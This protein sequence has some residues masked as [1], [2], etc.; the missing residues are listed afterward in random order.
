M[1]TITKEF[2]EKVRLALLAIRPNFDG[3]DGAFAKQWSI[4]GAVFSR[5]QKGQVDGVL[6]DV[7]WITIGRELGV[8]THEKKWNTAK[9]DVFV[10]IEQ[11]VLFCKEH[12][13]AKIFVDAC[14]I[15]KT[16]TAKYLSKTLRNCFYIDGSQ[17]KTKQQ[18]VRRIAKALGVDQIGTYYDVKENIKY[19]LKLLPYPIIIIDEAGDITNDAF[20]ELKE[21]WNAT[22]GYCGW[23]MIGA[24][25]LRA[26]IQRGITN[27]KVGY[28][29]IFSRF[30]S[31]YSSVVPTDRNEKVSFYKKLLVDVLEVNAVDK[32]TINHIVNKCIT[33]DDKDNIGGL[34]RAEGILIL[35]S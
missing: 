3:S 28:R 30:S 7:H 31:K 9:T 2:K 29:E 23:Y 20:L 4:N 15:G 16:H 22:E 35:N 19:Y 11:D 10:V 26:K 12:A 8:G 32:S 14:E 34:R 17:A 13:K 5:I 1:M 27:Q 6:A 33:K 24:D 21:F 18:F 25:G